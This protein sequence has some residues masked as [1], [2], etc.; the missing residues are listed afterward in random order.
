MDC[1][2]GRTFA[3]VVGLGIHQARGCDPG[4]KARRAAER[5]RRYRQGAG[6]ERRRQYLRYWWALYGDAQNAHRR[7][8]PARRARR[9]EPRFAAGMVVRDAP[10]VPRAVLLREDLAQ[11]RALADLVGDPDVLTSYLRAELAWLHRTMPLL[12]GSKIG[13]GQS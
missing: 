12:D 4:A 5:S 2:C 7:R 13:A 9:P 11:Q 10:P 8:G 1:S 6:K 3:S